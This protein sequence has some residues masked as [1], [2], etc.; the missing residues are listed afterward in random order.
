MRECLWD[1][2]PEVFDAAKTLESAVAAHIAGDR[3]TAEKLFASAD[4]DAIRDWTEHLWGAGWHDRFKLKAYT[5]PLKLKP[6][7][8]RCVQRMP[9]ISALREVV[10]RDGYHCRYCGIPVIPK[11]VRVRAHSLYPEA[12]SWGTTNRSQHAAFQ[13]MWMQFDHVIPHAYGGSNSLDNVV[14]SCAPCNNGRGSYLLEEIDLESPFNRSPHE[15]DWKGL[16][17]LMPKAWTYWPKR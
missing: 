11:E 3:P 2:V 15:S 4:I 9:P 16:L 6:K 12:I 13:C 5:G 1:P 7:S 10:L 17:D 8:D 14:V